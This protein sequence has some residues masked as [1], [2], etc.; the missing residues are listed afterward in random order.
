MSVKKMLE[1]YK[2]NI[3]ELAAEVHKAY[4]KVYEEQ[5]GCPYWTMG[6]YDRL[7]EGSKEFDRATAKAVIAFLEKLCYT[8]EETH[9][10]RHKLLHERLDE[11]IADWLKNNAGKFPSKE[12]VL[13]L[14]QW[15]SRQT[16]KP[17]HKVINVDG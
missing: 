14:M 2:Q 6:D 12:T 17:D 10:D 13:E 8:D 11:L 9:Q 4:C 15:S 7:S 3:E 5:K 1:N 16:K